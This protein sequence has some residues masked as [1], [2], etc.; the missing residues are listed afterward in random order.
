MNKMTW[1]LKMMWLWPPFFGTGIRVIAISQDL[2]YLKVQLKS[3]F[4]SKNYFGTHYGG[5]LYSMTD[6]FYAL[7]LV[8]RLGKDYT[9]WDKSASIHYKVAT[10][11]PVYAEFDLPQHSIE[12]LL[13]QLQQQTTVEPRF[14]I[15][16]SDAQGNVVAL[17]ERTLH[18]RKK[19][20]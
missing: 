12:Q 17:I 15:T 8:H 16:I 13:E 20:L 1:M 4:W 7:M 10:S 5:S 9:V 2:S 11:K 18:I 19:N 14:S 6:P 3:R